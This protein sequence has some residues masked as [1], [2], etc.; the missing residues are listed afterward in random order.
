MGI[1]S[2]SYPYSSCFVQLPASCNVA[3]WWILSH[4]ASVTAYL[5]ASVTSPATCTSETRICSN[6]FLWGTYNY[7]SC[8]V[9]VPINRTVTFNANGWA[10][11]TPTTKSIVSWSALGTLS[12]NP[13]RSGYTFGG[14][15]T[16]TTGW[17]IVSASTTISVDVTYYA[18]WTLTPINGVCN[19]S[20]ALYAC[21]T[22]TSSANSAG[23]CGWSATWTC[24]GSGW[25]S[26]ASCSVANATCTCSNGA[27][28]Y[29]TCD[30]C[31]MTQAISSTTWQC[32]NYPT[33]NYGGG[34]FSCNQWYWVADP[35]SPQI[36]YYSASSISNPGLGILPY[37][38]HNQTLI[39][40]FCR[41][42]GFADQWCTASSTLTC[43]SNGATI[44]NSWECPYP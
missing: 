14:W 38:A 22:G 24:L 41:K 30:A 37:W 18:R 35:T 21:S 44:G 11:Q 7:A 6:W 19:N 32:E 39:T 13:T 3:P 36:R 26:N 43:I 34:Y 12:T 1:L 20:A 9:V 4:N 8:S 23:S 28:N 27:L 33:C 16:A 2:G 42:D 31:P 40:Y 29:P 17:S 25:W 10:W 5:A 15:Y